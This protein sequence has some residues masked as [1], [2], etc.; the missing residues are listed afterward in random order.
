MQRMADYDYEHN[1]D[2]AR[3]LAR[4]L[5]ALKTLPQPT[6]ARVQGSAFGGAVGPDQLLRHRHRQHDAAASASRRTRIGLIPATIGPHVVEAIGPRWARRLFLSG[7][8]LRCRSAPGARPDSRKLRSRG[9]RRAVEALISTAAANGPRRCA[10]PR[11]WCAIVSGTPVDAALIEDTSAR[12][13]HIRVSGG[14]PGRA[15][16]VSEKSARPPGRR[17]RGAEHLMF[18]RILI[19]N[20][21][22]IACRVIPPRAAS[23]IAT[24]AVYSDADRDALHVSSPTRRCTSAPHRPPESYLRGERISRRRSAAAPRPSTRATAS[25]R[26]TPTLPRLRRSAGMVFIGPPADAIEAMGSKARAKAIMGEAGVPLIPGYHGD[27]QADAGLRARSR[28]HGL[29]GAAQ[30]HRRRRRQGH[31]RRAQ[32]GEDFDEALAAARRE[33]MA[34][35]GDDRM[36]VEKLISARATSRCRC[37]ATATA[38]ASICRARLLDPAPAPES[39]RGSTGAGPEPAAAQAMGE[40]A[41]D[42]ARAIDY[43]GAGTWSSSSTRAAAST[44][45][46]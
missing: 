45:W 31:A 40:A 32:R 8:A 6:L 5:H 1:L 29:S 10:P 39:H 35:F 9:T 42:A 2:D 41:V 7:R 34:S 44:S 24:V 38:T 17:R 46:K 3:A 27:D 4:M 25:C 33:A 16:G 22:E 15:A 19:A 14:R 12:I 20:R 36:L 37:S 18:D 13:A 21:G 11:P 43:R 30:G 28:R 26:R 23:G